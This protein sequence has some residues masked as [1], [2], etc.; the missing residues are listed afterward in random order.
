MSNINPA[1]TAPANLLLPA[2]TPQFR[3]Q[4]L[5]AA[6][7]IVLFFFIYI[8]LLISA[9]ALA[10][11]CIA[12]GIAL[13]FSF[14]KMLAVV[15]AL[16]LVLVGGML[17]LFL[18]SFLFSRQKKQPAPRTLLQAAE[19]PMLFSFI[20]ALTVATRTRLP[21]KVFAIPGVTAN[22]LY[23]P[24]N[25]QLE[26]GLGLVNSLNLSE[27]QMVLARALGRFSHSSMQLGAYVSILHQW[28]YHRLYEHGGR[29]TAMVRKAG[30]S[31]VLRPFSRIA[32]G[33][34]NGIQYLLRSLFG[35]INREYLPMNREM[36]YYADAVGL[37]V[38]GSKAAIS[39]M[40]RMEMGAFCLNNCLHELPALAAGGR[41][42]RNLYEAHSAWLRHYTLQNHLLPDAAGLPVIS[43]VYLQAFVK[44]RVQ[45]RSRSASQPGMEEREQRYRAAAV[46]RPLQTSG[47]WELFHEPLRLQEDLTTLL[48]RH[49][50]PGSEVYQWYTGQEL[51]ADLERRYHQ[52]SF[53][54]A[55][56]GYYDNRPFS[57]LTGAWRQPLSPSELNRLTLDGLYTSANTLRIRQFF[58]DRQ[59]AETL[60]AIAGREIPVAF[61][62]FEGQSHP[63][64]EAPELLAAML[65][66][67]ERQAN[68]LQAQDALAF[69]FHY[70]RALS[71]GSGQAQIMMQLYESVLLHQEK[72]ELL[73]ELAA[74]IVQCVGVLFATPDITM[75]EALPWFDILDAESSQ[76]KLLLQDMWQH[77]AILSAWE[78][79]LKQKAAHFLWHSNNYLED[80][81]PRVQEIGLLQEICAA[82]LEHY[83]NYVQFIKKW[84]LDFVL[85]LEVPS[86]RST[87]HSS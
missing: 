61:F 50:M 4:V 80:N 68:W 76:F 49:E 85:E 53:P 62:E 11:A 31:L 1:N 39:A 32:V 86:P 19:H 27:L 7:F 14:Q 40:H 83:N 24:G 72:A 52:H 82:V 18:I 37:Q 34:A 30:R 28:I 3:R 26:I 20:T 74:R 58:R 35:L 64:A 33:F 63:A 16:A 29:Y 77:Q 23:G 38:A 41:R 55:F 79:E 36:E 47:A 48:Y 2:P 15:T 66:A 43:D 5:K 12:G 21:A 6:G 67:V 8:V 25:G 69:R 81:T 17:L 45:F 56:K 22:V 84:Y 65:A 57:V 71:K 46:E 75:E 54:R 59:D 51:T 87:L 10:L 9:A 73:G 70:T 78:P 44:S 42:F 60:Q 13:V